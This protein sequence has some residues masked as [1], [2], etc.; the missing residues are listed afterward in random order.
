MRG[1]LVSLKDGLEPLVK[2]RRRCA[3][4]REIAEWLDKK[5]FPAGLEGV[6]C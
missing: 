3:A 5:T 4:V 2:V 6:L 1:E